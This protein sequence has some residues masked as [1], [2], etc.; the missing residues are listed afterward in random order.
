MSRNKLA[1]FKMSGEASLNLNIANNSYP[2]IVIARLDR[3]IQ[4][5]ELDSEPVPYL[6]RESC[7]RM[8]EGNELLIADAPHLL[9]N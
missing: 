5:K 1:G 4:R 6:I 7:R 2:P 3:A 8:T 9:C